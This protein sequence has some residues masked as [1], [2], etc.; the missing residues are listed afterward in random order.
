MV[1]DG[2]SPHPNEQGAVVLQPGEGRSIDLGGFEMTVKATREQ[3]DD[4]FTLLEAT[5][6]PG[7]G[8]PLHIHR[9]AA[10]AFYVLEGEYVMFIGDREEVGTSWIRRSY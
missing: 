3:T 9:N 8:P 6:P 2:G 5:E 10:E 4:A 1:P 7:F